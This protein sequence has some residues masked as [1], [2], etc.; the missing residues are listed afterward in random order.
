MVNSIHSEEYC[1]RRIKEIRLKN[2]DKEMSLGDALLLAH[3]LKILKEYK[4]QKQNH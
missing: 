4:Q 2:K 3:F 1:K